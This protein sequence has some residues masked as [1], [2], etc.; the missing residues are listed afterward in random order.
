MQAATPALPPALPIRLAKTAVWVHLL[1][2]L[3][4][5]VGSTAFALMGRGNQDAFVILGVGGAAWLALTVWS[6]LLNFRSGRSGE[7]SAL[8]TVLWMTL[9]LESSAVFVLLWIFDF[10][11]W[12]FWF[13]YGPVRSLIEFAFA[14]FLPVLLPFLFVALC[15][16][17]PLSSRLSQIGRRLN[18]WRWVAVIVAILAMLLLPWVIV[19]YCATTGARKG[20]LR[21]YIA[22]RAPKFICDLEEGCLFRSRWVGSPSHC[23]ILE[24]GCVSKERLIERMFDSNPDIVQSA[25]VA[26]QAE[27]PDEAV[28]RAVEFGSSTVV[29][30]SADARAFMFGYFVGRKGTHDQIRKFL[31]QGDAISLRMRNSLIAYLPATAEYLPDAMR[32]AAADRASCYLILSFIVRSKTPGMPELYQREWMKLFEQTDW[33]Y[34]EGLA[35]IAVETNVDR[36]HLVELC[37]NDPSLGM[38]RRAA[39]ALAKYLWEPE[40]LRLLLVAFDNSDL[41]VR[42]VAVWGVGPYLRVATSLT[43]NEAGAM[44]LPNFTPAAPVPG[45]EKEL[46][47][48]RTV[49]QKMLAAQVKK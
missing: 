11:H 22:T 41:A 48:A 35:D 34:R 30:A 27:Y 49:A 12:D 43:P 33:K 9:L 2:L 18:R 3:F 13:L 42:R 37:L 26:F 25:C 1:G 23:R 17:L 5:A 10:R 45:E 7:S 44:T 21:F 24:A 40:R 29:S 15:V 32:F 38:R 20:D 19:P 8:H 4:L 39:C 16:A 14:A 31:D 47:A 46:E 36:T 6:M 28:E